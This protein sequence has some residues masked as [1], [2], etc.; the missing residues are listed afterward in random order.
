MFWSQ[1]RP[2][3]FCP[4]SSKDFARSPVY[5][6]LF[7]SK[8]VD[9]N[10]PLDVGYK[11]YALSCGGDRGSSAARRDCKSNAR[12]CAF[13]QRNFQKLSQKSSQ[14]MLPLLNRFCQ[15]SSLKGTFYVKS[16]RQKPAFGRRKKIP[17]FGFPEHRARMLK[18]LSKYV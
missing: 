8:V 11:I 10:R 13:P 2:K 6:V 5:T 14:K 17:T 15:I 16:R 9:K 12:I 3:N 1:N 18:N 7:L 4:F